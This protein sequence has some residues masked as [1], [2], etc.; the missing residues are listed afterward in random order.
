MSHRLFDSYNMCHIPNMSH[1]LNFAEQVEIQVK[2]VKKSFVDRPPI[3]EC[4]CLTGFYGDKC[5]DTCDESS[6]L[7]E[8]R[9]E[10]RSGNKYNC[11]TSSGCQPCLA[12]L[13]LN[14]NLE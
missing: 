2:C 4:E 3:F 9:C 8:G 7:N 10:I 13:R 5:Q 6:C 12:L 1:G 14:G 11:L